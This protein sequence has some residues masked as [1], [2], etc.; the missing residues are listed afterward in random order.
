MVLVDSLCT[1]KYNHKFLTQAIDLCILQ[2][3]YLPDIMQIMQILTPLNYL[4]AICG[5]SQVVFYYIEGAY[6]KVALV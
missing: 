2:D 4:P 3:S 5:L 6:K 1:C